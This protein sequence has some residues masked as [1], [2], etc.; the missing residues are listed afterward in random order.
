MQ[1]VE[2]SI[3]KY[4]KLLLSSAGVVA[5]AFTIAFGLTNTAAGLAWSQD[6]LALQSAAPSVLEYKFEVATIKPS[7]PGDNASVAGFFGEDTFRARSYSMKGVIRFAYE[8]P[9]G[10]NDMLTGGPGWLD[11]ERYEVNAKM[12]TATADQLKKL[13]PDERTHTQNRM[14]QELL[15]DRLKLTIHREPRELPVYFLTIAKTGLKLK[16]AKPGDTYEKAFPY[17]AKFADAAKAGE[18]F[19][20]VGMHPGHNVQTAYAFGVSMP[21][22][23]WELTVFSQRNVQD[24]TGLKG[25]YDFVLEFCRDQLSSGSLAVAPDGQTLPSAV[26]PCGV[27]PLLSAVQQQLGLKMEAGKGSVEIIVIDHVERPSGN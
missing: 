8:T 10:M 14:L 5:V 18:I 20:L 17:A 22:L 2:N 15:A 13:R 9:I 25:S 19:L 26:D 4:R 7:R 6:R 3:G 27:P 11:S 21:A 23:A 12:D 1:R 16:E 24:R